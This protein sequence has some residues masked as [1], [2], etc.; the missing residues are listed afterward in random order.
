MP[1]AYPAQLSLNGGEF[2]PR[3]IAR[4]DFARY[5][6]GCS[7]L[8]NFLPL[9]QG[10]ATRRP[11]TVFV[12][13]IKDSLSFTRPLPFVFSDEQAYIIEA[14]SLYFR[15][16]RDRG[17]IEAADT[18][19]AIANGTFDS[20]ITSWTDQSGVGSSIAHDAANGR[21]SLTS[22]GTTNAHAEQSV[23]VTSAYQNALHVLRFRTFGAPGDKVKLRIG[24]S[25]TGTQIV[26]DLE[27]E[28]GFHTHSFTPGATTFYVQFLNSTGKT[29]QVDDIS[30]IDNSPV[31]VGTPYG[32]TALSRL[33]YAQSADVLYICHS[34]FPVYKLSR[35]GHSSWSMTEVAFQDGPWGENLS[36]SGTTMTPSSLTG[37]GVSYIAS[38]TAGINNGDG[39][40]STDIGR[41]VRTQHSNSWSWGVIVDVL[42]T[43]QVLVDIKRDNQALSA[44]GNIRLGAWSGATGYPA[45]V[46]F[47]EQRLCFAATSGQPQTLWLSQ[48]SD[49]ENMSPDS[50]NETTSDWDGTV[51]DDDAIDYTI[52]ADQ[53][54][55]IRSLVSARQLYIGTIGGEWT[56]DSDGSLLT[57]SDIAVRRQTTFGFSTVRPILLRGRMLFLQRAARK[58]MEFVFSLEQ[59]NFQALDLTVLAEH[60]SRTGITDIAYQQEPDSILWTVRTDGQVPSLT[61]LPEQGSSVI[62]WSRHIFGGSF[63]SG[64]AVCEGVAVIPV[65]GRDEPWFVIKRTI[66]GQTKRYFEYLP[67][68]F[69]TGDDETLAVYADSSLTYNGT[70]ATSISG[71]DHLEGQSVAIT[72]DGAVHPNKTVASGSVTLEYAAEKVVIG[73]PFTH[74]YESLRWEAGNPAGTAQGQTKRINGVTITLLESGPGTQ[75]GPTSATLSTIPWRSVTDSMDTA[76]PLFTGDKYIEIEGN[77]DTDTRVRIEGSS[78]VPF[79][80]LAVMPK[81][82]TNPR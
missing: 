40:K 47:F 36:G 12:A 70:S 31:E 81:I 77:Y 73:L 34:S 4:T 53:V 44:T 39:F 48:S 32:T 13:E 51:E 38:G 62:G 79:T 37:Y 7:V 1:I 2:S 16:Y 42:S 78:P 30:L 82:R 19:A 20:G 52:S 11:G 63:G 59:D 25:S 56:V 80:L 9:P 17:R 72:A 74:T 58:V 66:G 3:M 64:D 33:Q 65:D 57:P 55:V 50:L 61:Y 10:G 41:L 29:L 60:V 24:I 23:A 67:A 35:T 54:N 68:G 71:L 18:D 15:F 69:E 46:T 6:L 45:V 8:E 21:L 26:N 14:G 22:N 5:P 76:I 75:I 27:F 49:F 43:T 28:T